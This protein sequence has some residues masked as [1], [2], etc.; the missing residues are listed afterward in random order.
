MTKDEIILKVYKNE[1]I[2]KYCKAID[3]NNWQELKSE[4]VSQLYLMK[5]KKLYQ[6]YYNGFLE[7]LCFTICKRIKYGNIAD[8][9]VFYHHSSPYL[10]SDVEIKTDIE[11]TDTDY[12]DVLQKVLDL[13]DEQH[14]YSK[15]LFKH[16]YI[17]GLK[18]REI[19]EL[20]GINIKS[21]HYAIGKV[22]SEIKKQ[23]ENDN[24]N[25]IWS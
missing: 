5:D 6:A 8:T 18:L 15:I 13:L 11:D 1:S 10:L 25:T 16:Y 23:I 24:N 21:I 14:W 2:D 9:G 7:Y 19:S 20:Y 4:L 17:E 22:K 3:H 12:T